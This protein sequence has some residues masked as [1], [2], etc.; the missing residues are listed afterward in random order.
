VIYKY[1]RVLIPHIGAST[2][3]SIRVLSCNNDSLLCFE[4]EP[5]LWIF[6]SY[7]CVSKMT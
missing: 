4:P 1:F 5:V 2:L 3:E 6:D 7:R